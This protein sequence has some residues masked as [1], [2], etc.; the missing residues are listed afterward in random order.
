MATTKVGFQL[1]SSLA[2]KH[3]TDAEFIKGGFFVVDTYTNLTATGDNIKFYVANGEQDGTIVEGSL[4]YCTEDKKFYQ[5]NGSAWEEAKLGSSVSEG[6]NIDITEDGQISLKDE[7]ELTKVTTEVLETPMVLQDGDT[8][9]IA[10][11]DGNMVA[12]INESGLLTTDVNSSNLT[13]GN[14]IYTNKIQYNST[15]TDTTLSLS[16][17]AIRLNCVDLEIMEDNSNVDFTKANFYVNSIDILDKRAIGDNLI[18]SACYYEADSSV[19]LEANNKKVLIDGDI[20][21]YIDDNSEVLDMSGYVQ[22]SPAS[23][24]SGNIKVSGTIGNG[25]VTLDSYGLSWYGGATS[26]HGGTG[27]NEGFLIKSWSNSLRFSKLTLNNEV[28]ATY[29]YTLP[30]LDG[31]IALLDNSNQ[32][33]QITATSFYA[34]SDKRLKENIKE[35]IPQKSILDLPVVEFDFKDSGEHT[36]GCLAQDLQEICPQIVN[37]N[38]NGY[39]SINENK[40]IY[41]LLDEVKKLRKEINLLKEISK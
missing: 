21:A 41:L 6:T 26:I 20:Q 8:L 17:Q 38:D 5:Y 16:G 18:L 13:V 33:G 32:T 40:I 23:T 22:L 19:R 11:I 24:Q 25:N 2:S 39:L 4:C 36:I 34:T 29:K 31:T 12:Q 30:T 14:T 3:L 10:D 7:I 27:S 37:E 1:A 15:S 9:S 28:S 35:F